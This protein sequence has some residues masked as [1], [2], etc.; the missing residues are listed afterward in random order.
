MIKGLAT[1]AGLSILLGCADLAAG[2]QEGAT[3]GG[4][5]ED[6]AQAETIELSPDEP[7]RGVTMPR[8]VYPPA[9]FRKRI[10]GTV[11]LEIVIDAKGRVS[12]TRVLQSV[13]GLD[14]AAIDCVKRWEF[15]PARKNGQPVATIA[16]APVTFR[17]TAHPSTSPPPLGKPTEAGSAPPGLDHRTQGRVG[18]NAQSE[19]LPR[20]SAPRFDPQGADFTAWLNHFRAEVYANWIAPK[21][22]EL[23]PHAHADLEFTVE[24]DGSVSSIRLLSP[25]GTPAFDLAAMKALSHGMFLRLP[26]RY[27]S[28]QVTM[29]VS[30][31][32]N[33]PGARPSP[34]PDS[35]KE[36]ASS[37]EAPSPAPSPKDPEGL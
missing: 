11:V 37:G 22:A 36:P 32:D 10:E 20:L 9:A 27:T 8:P 24:R 5:D 33:E 7:P 3:G 1:L 2:Q 26:P 25:S 14:E 34:P 31:S 21:P 17:I 19:T 16:R 35:P 13:A 23:G 6:K 30:F 15:K 18:P 29:D 28:S 12:R 4:S